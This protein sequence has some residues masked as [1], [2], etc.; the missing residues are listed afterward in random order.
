[1]YLFYTFFTTGWQANMW[2]CKFGPPNTFLPPAC[3]PNLDPKTHQNSFPSISANAA[4][5]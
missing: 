1:M 3:G 4:Q 5:P 2:I